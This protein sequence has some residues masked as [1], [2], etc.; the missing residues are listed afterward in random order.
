MSPTGST[1]EEMKERV[2]LLTGQLLRPTRSHCYLRSIMRAHFGV[3]EDH[4]SNQSSKLPPRPSLPS[5][6]TEG[7]IVAADR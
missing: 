4:A 3:F 5:F 7:A 1:A 2:R 6:G